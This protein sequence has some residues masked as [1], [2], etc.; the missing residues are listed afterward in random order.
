MDVISEPLNSQDNVED[1]VINSAKENVSCTCDCSSNSS[2]CAYVTADDIR[3]QTFKTSDAT[4]NLYVSYAR[5]VG[6]GVRKGDATRG[7]DGCIVEDGF[8]VIGKERDIRN[9]SPILIRRESI[10]L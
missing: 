8:F 9:S 4:Y 1:C 3:N 10:K 2:K 6:F 5:C 7:K